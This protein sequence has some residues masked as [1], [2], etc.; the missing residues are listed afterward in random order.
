MTRIDRPTLFRKALH[1]MRI[2]RAPFTSRS[3]AVSAGISREVTSRLMTGLRKNGVIVADATRR[4]AYTLAPKGRKGRV[5]DPF[6]STPC[7]ALK[8]EYV[9]N[10]LRR[11]V[12]ASA[13]ELAYA[14]STDDVR[15]SEATTTRYLENWRRGGAVFREGDAAR[16]TWR[17]KPSANTGPKPPVFRAGVYHDPNVKTRGAS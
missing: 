1:A 6:A 4:G 16:P 14:A 7:A 15:I 12:V 10:A 2:A 11:L 5:E 13:R 9:W 17:L 8:R 3:I